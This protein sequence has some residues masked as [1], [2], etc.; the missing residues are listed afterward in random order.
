[1]NQSLSAVSLIVKFSHKVHKTWLDDFAS[2]VLPVPLQRDCSFE[3]FPELQ[4][5]PIVNVF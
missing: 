5:F 3:T 4:I 2:E 1:M